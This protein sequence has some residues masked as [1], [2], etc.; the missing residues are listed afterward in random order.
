MNKK[1]ILILIMIMLM[2]SCSKSVEKKETFVPGKLDY[3]EIQKLIISEYADKEHAGPFFC[4]Y[5]TL[6][7]EEDSFYIRKY[8]FAFIEQIDKNLNSDYSVT[9]PFVI[10]VDKEKNKIVR[11]IAYSDKYID[12]EMLQQDFPREIFA[13]VIN[14]GPDEM[15]YKMEQMHQEILKHARKYY[16]I[17]EE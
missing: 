16:K 13:R 1:I 12:Q 17:P 6:W 14:A 4:V 11:H 8:L 2:I 10:T 3:D 5:E 15:S 9:L 7:I